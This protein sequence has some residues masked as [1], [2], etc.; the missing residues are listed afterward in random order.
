M[1]EQAKMSQRST[2]RSKV[3]DIDSTCTKASDIGTQ[4][5]LF[6]SDSELFIDVDQMQEHGIV[7]DKNF[8][9]IL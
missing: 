3:K 8:S 7:S 2:Q 1:Q 6:D 4:N 9:T 5:E